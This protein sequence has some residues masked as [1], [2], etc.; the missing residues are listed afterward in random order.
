MRSIK[1]AKPG[2]CLDVSGFETPLLQIWKN[3]R[4]KY[5]GFFMMHKIFNSL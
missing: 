5:I 2:T 3:E 1:N 4:H